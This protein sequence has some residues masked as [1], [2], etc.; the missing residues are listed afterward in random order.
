MQSSECKILM[1]VSRS[2]TPK[3]E[4]I[5]CDS[6][7]QLRCHEADSKRKESKIHNALTWYMGPYGPDIN[8]YEHI[9]AHVGPSGSGRGRFWEAKPSWKVSLFE[10]S[11]FSIKTT[12]C[13][14]TRW[15]LGLL[16][17]N[18][19]G[20]VSNDTQCHQTDKRNHAD[21]QW[22][23]FEK[24]SRQNDLSRPEKEDESFLNNSDSLRLFFFFLLRRP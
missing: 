23:T 22:T 11:V 19:G 6:L 17:L 16:Y 13:L 1:Q 14:Q 9:R 15:F 3:L 18:L 8:P 24:R 12:V 20:S 21:R 7:D 4:Q 2:S 5:I 10:I